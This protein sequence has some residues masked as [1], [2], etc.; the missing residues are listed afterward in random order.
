[1]N[2]LPPNIRAQNFGIKNRRLLLSE[3]II[4]QNLNEFHQNLVQKNVK[5]ELL[6][7]DG[8][9]TSSKVVKD[10]INT[11]GLNSFKIRKIKEFD[12][13]FDAMEYEVKFLQNIRR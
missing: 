12:N 4:I 2:A 8:Y 7:E 10:I 3:N 1:M 5:D 9:Q 11:E 6:Q 13:K